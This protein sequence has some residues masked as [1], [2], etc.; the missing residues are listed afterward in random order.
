MHR[1]YDKSR[2]NGWVV[3]RFQGALSI[4]RPSWLTMSPLR[5][6]TLLTTAAAA[7]VAVTSACANPPAL[8]SVL[9]PP[10]P[11]PSSVLP[12]TATEVMHGPRDVPAVALTFHGQGD[13]GVVG[14]LLDALAREQT[15]VTVLAVGTWL[16]QQPDLAKQVV[17]AG[18]ELGNH[19]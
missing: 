16:R 13:P 19:T 7:G 17:A 4:R 18:H 15:K 14:Q 8:P 12:S 2:T 1:G 9:A 5:R 11:V 10:S 3:G 6:R